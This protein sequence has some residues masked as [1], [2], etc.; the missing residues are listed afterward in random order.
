MIKEL[1]DYNWFP[2]KLRRWQLE[3]VGSISIWVKLY[4]PLSAILDKIIVDNNIVAMQDLCSGSGLPAVQIHNAL[5]TKLPLLLTDKYPN[6][7]FKNNTPIAYSLHSVDVNN[8]Q[9]AQNIC[10]TM[11]NAFHHFSRAEKK[12]FIEKVIKTSNT[13]LIAEIVQPGFLN[14]LKIFFTTTLVQI[15]TAP[16]VHPFSLARLF[17][18]YLVPINL[19]TVTYDGIVSVLKSKTVQEYETLFKNFDL[20]HY[21]IEINKIHNWKGNLIYIKGTPTAI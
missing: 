5:I 3:F 6:E 20:P 15:F 19:F 4:K 8:L 14:G 2:A 1:E 10:Y 11:Y 9:P 12:I 17:F 18:T 21:N 16:F 13:F 7:N